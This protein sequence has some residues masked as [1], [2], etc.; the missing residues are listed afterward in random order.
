MIKINHSNNS[1][2]DILVNFD[3]SVV[4]SRFVGRFYIPIFFMH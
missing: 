4:K 1:T 2:L 3:V